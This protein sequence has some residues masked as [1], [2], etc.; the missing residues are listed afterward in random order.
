MRG[1]LTYLVLSSLLL[2]GMAGRVQAIATSNNTI[3]AQS[4]TNQGYSLNWDYIYKYK[5]SSSVAVDHYWILT[6]AHVGDD[7][8]TGNLVVNGET[9]TQQEVV[10]HPSADLALVRY[11]KPFPG[12][13]ALHDGEVYHEEGPPGNPTAVYDELIMA[14][15]GRTGIV[16]QATFTNGSGGNGTKRWGTNKGNGTEET[17]NA[18][19]G[20]T[21]GN[22]STECFLMPFNLSDTDFEGGAAQ[23]DSGGPVFVDNGS[24]WKLTGINIYLTGSN[25]YTGNYAAMIP[26]YISWITNNIPDYDTDMDGLPDWWEDEHSVSEAGGYSDSDS[27]TNYEEWLADTDPNDGNSFLALSDYTNATSVVF[28]SSA[29]RKY[30]VQYQTNLTNDIWGTEVDWFTGFASQTTTNVS[31]T[32]SNRFYRIR[33]KLQ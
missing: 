26:D 32:T 18:N 25:P 19:V 2:S 12:Y 7:G 16:T 5:N 13:Y 22:V 15:Y 30:Q 17:V 14:G 10:L 24:G 4:P 33:V 11:D 31:A 6:A 1:A 20:G 23:H 27:F 28:S 21:A 8:G 29:N 9:Y 3:S